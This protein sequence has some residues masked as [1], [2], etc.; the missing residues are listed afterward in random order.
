MQNQPKF[1]MVREQ[2]RTFYR[3]LSE[4]LL[5]DAISACLIADAR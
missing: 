1:S 4:N 2:V 5:P 3:F